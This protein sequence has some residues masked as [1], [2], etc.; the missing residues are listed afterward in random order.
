MTPEVR[1]YRHAEDYERVGA[2][3]NRTYPPTG[4]HRNWLQPRW[5]YMHYHPLLDPATLGRIGVWEAAGQIVGVVHHEH[6]MGDVYFEL[7]PEFPELRRPMLEFAQAHLTRE[8]AEGPV[9]RAYIDAEDREFE[10][11]AEGLGFRKDAGA[12]ECMSELRIPRPF[13]PIRVPEGFALKSL[14]DEDD[15]RKTHR[16]LHRGFNHPGEPPEEGIEGRRL[17]Q[18]APN[19][20]KDLTIVVTAPDGSFVSFCG[21]WVVPEHRLAYVEPVATDP[22]YRRRGLGTAA[23][24]EGVRRCGELGATVAYVGTDKPFYKSMGFR[25]VYRQFVWCKGL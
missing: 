7:D 21:M 25:E 23:V 22:D 17:M 24:L 12:S 3:L 1:C 16:V 18:S 15:L 13:P 5:E 6:R 19:F 9:L 8:E 10:S 4:T 11:I 2:F 14:A 20:R